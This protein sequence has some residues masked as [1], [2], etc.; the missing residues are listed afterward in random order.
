ML[1]INGQVKTVVLD[2]KT[3]LNKPTQLNFDLSGRSASASDKKHT[4]M[5]WILPALIRVSAVAAGFR[6]MTTANIVDNTGYTA[7]RQRQFR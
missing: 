5:V 7:R 6:L 1:V 2:A 4:K 3:Q